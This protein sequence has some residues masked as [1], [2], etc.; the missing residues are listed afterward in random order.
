MKIVTYNIN[1]LRPRISQHGSLLKLLN[2][3]QADIIC[4]QETKLSREEFTA[5]LVMAEGYE[6]FF[7]CTSTTGIGRTGYSGVATFCRV[8][9]AFSSKEVALPVAAEEGFTGLLEQSRK[10]LSAIKKN[11]PLEVPAELECLEGISKDELLEVDSEGRCVITDHGHFV[12]FNI[13]GPR[14]D[15]GDKERTQFKLTFYNILQKRWEALLSQG[16]RVIIVGDLNIAPS[17]IDRCDADP[18]FEENQTEAY[19]C[20]STQTGAEQFNYGS[21]IDHILIAGSC[22]HQDEKMEGHNIIYCHVTECDIMTQFKRWKPENASSHRWKGGRNI[23]LE[24]SDHAPVYVSFGELPDLPEHNTPSLAARYVPRIRGFQQTIVTLLSK[25]QV[26]AEIKNHGVSQLSYDDVN[27]KSCGNNSKRSLDDCSVSGSTS[28]RNLP[29]SN[30]KC[31][32][33]TPSISK[34]IGG[35]SVEAEE[36]TVTGGAW[37]KLNPLPPN[38]MKTSKKAR[39]GDSSQRT[40]SSYFIK[41]PNL[42]VV[43]DHAKSDVLPGQENAAVGQNGSYLLSDEVNSP[44]GTFVD[45]EEN[46]SFPNSQLDLTPS[47]SDADACSSSQ[48]EKSDVALSEWQRIQQLMDKHKQVPLCKG[49]KE[50]CVPRVV[51]KPGPNLGRKFYVCCRA[52]GPSSNPETNCGYFEWAAS[53]S[54]KK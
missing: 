48:K 46:K 17:A 37:T 52:E 22:L 40:L 19:T 25:R 43:V 10:R 24:G 38:K 20:W 9:S 5:D 51:K 29:S 39:G 12:L 3:L 4:F 34:H 21:R 27:L 18:K 2:S 50:P 7:S 47:I 54:R 8:N 13:Y 23:K 11:L 6:S 1:G 31:D 36:E 14:A 44:N 30:Q 42:S 28:I 41:K 15:H 26:A 49:H 53:K 16:K 45:N 33:F 32:D 35:T